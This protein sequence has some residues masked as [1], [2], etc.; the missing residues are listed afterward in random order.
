[1]KVIDFLFYYLARL[2][3]I[4]DRRKKKTVP[5]PDQVSYAISISSAVWIVV[6]DGIIEYYLFDSFVSKIPIIVYLSLTMFEYFWLRRIYIK[7]GR[8]ERLLEMEDPKFGVSDKVGITIAT[9]VFFL[10]LVALFFTALILH[11]II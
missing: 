5:Y 7:K 1:M 11:S 2:M 4:T 9:V 6:F 8:Y 3:E 10:P